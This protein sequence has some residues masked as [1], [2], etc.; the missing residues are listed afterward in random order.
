MIL[1]NDKA[2]SYL[3]TNK[4][5]EHEDIYVAEIVAPST[6][7]PVQAPLRGGLLARSTLTDQRD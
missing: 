6:I 5:Q 1:S 3:L 4:E 7:P 2:R